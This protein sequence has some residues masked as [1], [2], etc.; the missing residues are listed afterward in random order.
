MLDFTILKGQSIMKE[1]KD[2]KFAPVRKLLQ[3][4]EIF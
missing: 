2:E 4:Q 1:R 3:F